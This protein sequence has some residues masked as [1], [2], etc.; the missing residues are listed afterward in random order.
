MPDWQDEDGVT[1]NVHAPDD[2]YELRAR[3][4]VGCDGAHSLV[5]KKAGIGFPG[6]TPRTSC[7]AA[8]PDV[9]LLGAFHGGGRRPR[10]VDRGR[11]K[12]GGRPAPEP[13]SLPGPSR[14]PVLSGSPVGTGQKSSAVRIRSRIQTPASFS[15]VVPVQGPPAS[16]VP[17]LKTAPERWSS[18]KFQ[19]TQ[20]IFLLAI[21]SR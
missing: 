2:D 20:L 10:P 12:G 6:V 9:I 7:P 17:V 3:Y 5:R 21:R 8:S 4:L 11:G 19:F 18:E 15:D 13:V 16:H 14:L 1:V